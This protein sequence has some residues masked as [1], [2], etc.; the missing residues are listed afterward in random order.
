MP[1]GLVSASGYIFAFLFI[2]TGA[3]PA[4][5]FVN[6]ALQRRGDGKTW[7]TAFTT[8]Q[9]G[10]YAA[11][12]GDTVIVAKGLYEEGVRFEGKN[13]VLCS[14]D[15]LDAGVVAAT[16]IDAMQRGSV[17]TFA[18]T[19]KES[20]VLT[21]FT[22]R[23]GRA[24]WR[25]AGICGA[26]G[27]YRTRA[28][29][30]NNVIVGNYAEYEGGGLFYCNGTIKDNVIKDN[31]SGQNGGG[32]YGC[33]G[34][35][36]NNVISGN[37]T[38]VRMTPQA[39]GGGL[40]SCQ[41]TIRG[42]VII[43][44]SSVVDGG[45]LHYCDGIVESNVVANN[46]ARSAGG[47][48]GYCRG[49]IRNNVVYGNSA[50]YGGGLSN[51]YGTIRNNTVANNSAESGGGLHYCEGIPPTLPIADCII[52]GNEAT[53]HAQ[54]EESRDPTYSCIEDYTGTGVGN[55]SAFPYFVD[56]ASGDFHLKSWSPCIDAGNPTSDFSREPE[57]NGGR[58]DM[59]AYG[60]TPEATGKSPDADGDSLPDDWEMRFFGDL[61]QVAEGD[62]DSDGISNADEYLGGTRPVRISWYVDRSRPS[63]G[64]GTSWEK[65][66]KTI[67]EAM[68]LAYYPDA[69]TVAPGIYFENIRFKGKDVV[70]TSTGPLN[71][72]VVANTV[73]DGNAA[74]SVVT[75]E[76]TEGENCVLA[77]FTIRNGKAMSGGG[78]CGRTTGAGNRATIRNNVIVGNT[79]T[80]QG[81][82][83]FLCDGLIECNTIKA[84][85][86]VQHGGGLF[87][88]N[89]TIRSNTISG[90]LSQFQG[91]GLHACSG[92]IRN[93]AITGNSADDGGAMFGCNGTI[94]N[95]TIVGNSASGSG[96]ALHDCSGTIR[97]CIIWG[98]K[99][100]NQI[101]GPM[102]ATYCCIERWTGGGE[103]N[104]PHF[105]YFVDAAN[106][107][108]HLKSWSPCIDAGDPSSDFSNEPRDPRGGRIDIG[109]YGNTEEATSASEDADEDLLPDDWELL[110]FASLAHS[111]TD[112]LD[113]DGLANLA[114][115]LFST[116]PTTQDT[117]GDQ[118]PDAW[119]V[120]NALDPLTENAAE[121]ADTDGLTNLQEYRSSTDPN[122]SDSDGD[123]LSDGAEV[124]THR[125]DP[126][127]F[128][129]D[130]DGKN[131]SQEVFAGTDPLDAESLFQIIEIACTPFGTAVRWTVVPGRTYQC[132]VSPDLRL[133]SPL[134]GTVSPGAFI[135][136]HSVFDW[137][138]APLR[139]RYYRVSVRQ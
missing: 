10:M 135:S 117:D 91:G 2:A 114:E 132:Y 131:D 124:S 52:W 33:N 90:N 41:G 82:G 8:I 92:I 23:N 94:E 120:E 32:L 24:S 50:R 26:T 59:G 43:G 77:G 95:N 51:C 37:A 138:S 72:T 100:K 29:I 12:D 96:A 47:G 14:T 30:Q 113:G 64:D 54:M 128:D 38:R 102:V 112:D 61:A 55:I 57:P 44:N 127:K 93:N 58:I 103:G 46:A 4:T 130:S 66:F 105:P 56:A 115:Y 108:Y 129:T 53:Q 75:F 133:W 136:T 84:N 74:G 126:L 3:H 39:S 79:A 13:V 16:V 9:E 104:I 97:N 88:C 121:D 49:T 27:D 111:G 83:L 60:N 80:S 65:A 1:S 17:V 35:I 116:S 15:P 76:G 69:V 5:W 134:G 137:D 45:G 42:N 25:G 81:G 63:S 71:A 85:S 109:M 20:C 107:D 78:I 62:A 139:G 21:G 67:Q 28:T 11:V 86:A 34:V 68:D 48:L 118:M 36:E 73:V 101:S 110:T 99:G 125:T 70:L 106:D 7:E 122:N 98:N 19:E 40:D 87:L 119:E 22:L 89:G 18:G 123:D 6:G 31:S